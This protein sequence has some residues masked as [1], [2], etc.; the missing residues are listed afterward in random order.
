VT[1]LSI[2][3]PVFDVGG[4]IPPRY[5]CDGEN[6]S[7]PISISGVSAEARTLV[8]IMEDRDVPA[9]VKADRIFDHWILFNIPAMTTDIREG[10]AAGIVGK[11]GAGENSYIA[12]CPPR[13]YE[14]STHRYF[15][16]LYA[17][18]AELSLTESA[19]RTDV[20]AAMAGHVLQEALVIGT[21]RKK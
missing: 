4:D 12:P 21:Y 15:F 9:A 19:A 17:L 10:S 14:P 6:L 8:L 20:E 2:T 1:T 5:T 13:E 11:N 16:R 7:P 18:D 3:V